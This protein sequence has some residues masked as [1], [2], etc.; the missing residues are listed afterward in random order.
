MGMKPFGHTE[1]RTEREPHTAPLDDRLDNAWPSLMDDHYRY[2][3]PRRKAQEIIRS[4]APT[5]SMLHRFVLN[6]S[7]EQDVDWML[8]S[9]L[10]NTGYAH[11][12]DSCIVYDLNTPWLSFVGEGLDKDLHITGQVGLY[13]G[14]ELRGTFINDG[15]VGDYA[16]YGLIGTF[17]NNGRT[18]K[19]SAKSMIG[20][21]IN[22]GE[23][24]KSPAYEMIGVYTDHRAAQADG[25][26]LGENNGRW[27]IQKT[28][29]DAFLRDLANPTVRDHQLLYSRLRQWYRRR[30]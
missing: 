10:L 14:K 20:T 16:A 1:T 28:H 3:E 23:T 2:S 19:E 21:F 30:P 12:S 29:R 7:I 9:L 27:N 26:L 25:F 22:N 24:G 15:V 5:V 8:L 4:I 6:R 17:I 11:A 13:A 18:G